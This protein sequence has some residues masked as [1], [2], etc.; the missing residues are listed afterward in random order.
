M[1]DKLYEATDRYI[2]DT[3]IYDYGVGGVIE[4]LMDEVNYNYTLK[5]IPFDE[6][7]GVWVVAWT[8]RSFVHCEYFYY[9]KELNTFG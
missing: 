2:I 1:L 4:E 3:N 9:N 5:D 8:H 6:T 7:V